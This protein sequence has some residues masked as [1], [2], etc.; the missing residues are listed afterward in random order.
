MRR[1]LLLGGL[2]VL[3]L[4]GIAYVL[5]TTVL[6]LALIAFGLGFLFGKRRGAH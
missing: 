6:V 2:I 3:G 1:I 4:A 5:G